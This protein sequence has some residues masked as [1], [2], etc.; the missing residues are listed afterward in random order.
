MKAKKTFSKT[1]DPHLFIL[2]GASGDLSKRKILPALYNLVL[3][4]IVPRNFCIL[5]IS[6]RIISNLTFHELFFDSLVKYSSETWKIDVWSD[7]K[8]RVFGL[9]FDIYQDE[10]FD[11]L[12]EKLLELNENFNLKMKFLFYLATAPKN[13]FQLIHRLYGKNLLTL[14]SFIFYL[15]YEALIKEKKRYGVGGN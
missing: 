1:P 15:S 8:S 6:R 9:P 7:L 12:K 13:Y 5:G 14:N 2:F 11:R 4:G 3:E 10:S